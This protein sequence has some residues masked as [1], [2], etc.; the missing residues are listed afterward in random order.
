MSLHGFSKLLLPT[1]F[2]VFMQ[3]SAMFTVQQ[4]EELEFFG[5]Q[6]LEHNK[7]ETNAQLRG[8][9]KRLSGLV[10]KILQESGPALENQDELM[11]ENIVMPHV[12][13]LLEQ[14]KLNARDR[15]RCRSLVAQELA[16]SCHLRQHDMLNGSMNGIYAQLSF[17]K[18]LMFAFVLFLCMSSGQA[19]NARSDTCGVE[20]GLSVYAEQFAPIEQF[21][22][23]E[24]RYCQ[25]EEPSSSASRSFQWIIQ[26]INILRPYYR[27]IQQIRVTLEK[28]AQKFDYMTGFKGW[29]TPNEFHSR[30][31]KYLFLET[32]V[33]HGKEE[34]C[35]LYTPF[36][37]VKLLSGGWR[38]KML[39]VSKDFFS[40]MEWE[41]EDVTQRI[42]IFSYKQDMDRKIGPYRFKT[43]QWKGAGC[44]S[45]L[46]LIKSI[47]SA[48]FY[49]ESSSAEEL[50]LF[51]QALLADGQYAK[52]VQQFKCL[53]KGK[54]RF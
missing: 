16:N 12:E 43:E 30:T 19:F 45:K 32:S 37:E 50:I 53:S 54:N 14:L 3:A 36:G 27:A 9:I 22:P 28:S 8:F 4:Q 33:Y 2:C 11:L 49:Q 48:N 23:I 35:S 40:S 15:D 24:D 20:T 46:Y 5:Q 42:H 18:T 38:D 17:A 47:P 44:E 25:F 52:D 26:D 39:G 13:E 21:C 6:L 10:R 34:L 31:P 1:I 7:T 29:P 51:D 41:L